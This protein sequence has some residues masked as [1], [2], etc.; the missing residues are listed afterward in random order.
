MEKSGVQ[1][2]EAEIYTQDY[3]SYLKQQDGKNSKGVVYL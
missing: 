2:R 1:W 3:R